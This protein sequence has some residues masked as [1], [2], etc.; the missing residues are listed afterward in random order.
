MSY[1]QTAEYTVSCEK[2]HQVGIAQVQA[3]IH[4]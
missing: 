1:A 3:R 2:V 4:L